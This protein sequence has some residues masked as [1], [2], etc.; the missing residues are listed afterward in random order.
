MFFNYNLALLANDCGAN[1]IHI[2][3]KVCNAYHFSHLFYKP[4]LIKCPLIN[5]RRYILIRLQ[6]NRLTAI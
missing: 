6:I 1:L 5:K 4:Q 2:A 3:E